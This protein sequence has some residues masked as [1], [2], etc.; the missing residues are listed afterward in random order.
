[1]FNK[2]FT[3]LEGI[4]I[5][6]NYTYWYRAISYFSN[7]LDHDNNL[8]CGA[9]SEALALIFE[10]GSLEKFWNDESD[11]SPS[12]TQMQQ[13]LRAH[14]LKR[15]NC[16]YLNLRTE[17]YAVKI[18]NVSRYFEVIVYLLPKSTLL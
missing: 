1:M 3:I 2:Q 11:S 12:Y 13:S 10:T 4:D 17:K 18:R 9:A 5:Y 16:A 14:L 7:L 8:V 6:N 15:V